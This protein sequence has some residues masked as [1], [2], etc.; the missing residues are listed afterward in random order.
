MWRGL[1]S[2][3]STSAQAALTTARLSAKT[4]AMIRAI[5]ITSICQDHVDEDRVEEVPAR[6]ESLAALRVV[7]RLE[8]VARDEGGARHAEHDILRIER[9]VGEGDREVVAD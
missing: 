6:Q 2:S 4:A 5:T 9:A 3:R 8:A 1:C 7:D